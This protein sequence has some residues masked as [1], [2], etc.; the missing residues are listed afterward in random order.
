MQKK[1]ILNANVGFVI[2]NFRYGLMKALEKRGYKVICVAQSDNSAEKIEKNGWKFISVSLERRGKNIIKDLK[3]FIEYI[4]IFHKEKPDYIF[5]FT[6]KPNIYGAVAA[7][8]L[9][10]PTINNVTGLGD[11]FDG[12]RC[13]SKIVSLLYKIA[14]KF[15][16]RIFFQNNDDMNIFLSNGLVK[17]DKCIRIPGSGVDTSKFVPVE[18]K[19]VDDKIRFLFLG[20][21]SNKKGVRII[22][23]VSK[24]LTPKYPNIQFQ[25]LGK[26]YTDEAEHIS[27]EEI[28]EWEKQSNIRYLGTSSDVRNEISQADCIIF[29]S[30]YREGVPRSLIESAAM[31]KPIL[32]TDNVGC[33]DIVED[34]YNGYLAEPKSVE[35]M[36][37][38]VE[39]FLNLRKD[40]Q[41][42]LGEN[43]RKKAVE[44]FDERIVIRSYLNEMD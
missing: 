16:K 18:K 5:N 28:K 29:P 36:L 4:K 37:N 34:G 24:I 12:G 33:R 30:F 23:E 2:Y 43:G 32:T 20:R 22:N 25:L 9:G 27:L 15:P 6:I 42:I 19:T 11:M 1:V 10:I 13:N 3:L 21:I 35:S 38:I 31:G 40:Q 17:E 41:K 26:I 8:L 39:K 44:Q 14:F 7:K